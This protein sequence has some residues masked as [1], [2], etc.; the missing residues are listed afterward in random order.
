MTIPIGHIAVDAPEL[1]PYDATPQAILLFVRLREE[2]VRS[3]LRWHESR[4][5]QTSTDYLLGAHESAVCRLRNE[6]VA[7]E[8]IKKLLSVLIDGEVMGK[9]NIHH[10]DCTTNDRGATICES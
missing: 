6:L 3:E 1:S 8:A 2:V 5:Q 9:G 7:L 4:I 10:S